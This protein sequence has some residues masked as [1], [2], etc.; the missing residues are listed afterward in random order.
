MVV[1]SYNKNPD[2]KKYYRFY[3]SQGCER[4][5]FF[6]HGLRFGRKKGVLVTT[7]GVKEFA[8]AVYLKIIGYDVRHVIHDWLPHPGA[9][10]LLVRF[11]NFCSARLFPL[12][13]H[14]RA[15]AEVFGKACS[16]V[17][18][19]L[20]RICKSSGEPGRMVILAFGRNESY[21]NHRYLEQLATHPTFADFEFL[22]CSKG[23]ES[24]VESKRLEVV[25]SFLS[26]EELDQRITSS[27]AVILPYLSATQSGVIIDAYE[28]CVPVV[29]S[30]VNGLKEYVS[31]TLGSTFDLNSLSS[32]RR[33]LD[34]VCKIDRASMLT[35]LSRWNSEKRL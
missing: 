16:I 5:S 28:R 10:F 9:K 13:F 25:S 11:Y 29:V 22:I 30:D 24:A 8:A 33:A 23:Y 12:V 14:S 15:Q 27:K 31:E 35:E 26:D 3:L 2:H 1:L 20:V 7:A 18:L 32:L 4:F 6:Q 34:Y 21:K 19:P 17:P